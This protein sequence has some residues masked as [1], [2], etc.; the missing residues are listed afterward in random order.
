MRWKNVLLQMA[1]FNLSRTRP[2]FVKRLIQRGRRAQPAEGL[3]RRHPLQ[4]ELQPVGPAHVPGPRRATCSRRS[5]HG[6]ATIVTDQIETFTETGI[7]LESGEELEADLVVTATGLDLIPV[8]GDGA[9]GRRRGGPL[10][11]T[12]SLQGHDAQRR[13][14]LGDRDRLHER[15]VDAQ[16]RPHV[17]VRVPAAQPH[18][19]ARLRR[20]HARERATR[21]WRPMPFID[22]NSGYVLRAVDKFP[23][24]GLEARR[25]GSTRT[26]RATS[27]R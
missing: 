3:R 6:S 27:W 26:T 14:E 17:R 18:G 9:R 12:M 10:P 5:R 21:R 15:L 4:A 8:G 7:K 24:P 11:E 22:F 19:R 23:K 20:L 13:P 25:G 1:F 2:R 16:V